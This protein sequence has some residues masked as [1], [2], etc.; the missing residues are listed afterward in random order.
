MATV[1][2]PEMPILR[3]SAD[4][5]YQRIY[6]R[7]VELASL[8]GDTPPSPEEGQIFYD[9]QYPLAEEISEQQQLDEYKFLQW[10]LPWSDG[11]F[12]DAW[13]VFLGLKRKENELDKPY[14]ERLLAKASEEEGSGAIYDYTRWVKEVP[15]A[16]E[17]Y[18]WG[19]APNTVHIAI[20]GENG[21]PASEDL[22]ATVLQHL[23][24][25][26]RHH[27]NDKLVVKPSEILEIT[28]TGTITVWEPDV[29]IE[30]NILEIEK[31]IRT[32][33]QEQTKKIVYSDLYRLFKVDGVL[34]YGQVTLNGGQ[35]NVEI[36]FASIPVI[37][38]L[39]V[40]SQ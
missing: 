21:L 27:M 22:V 29:S 26:D 15:G 34:D 32:Y 31:N 12:L 23:Q 40:T 28:I 8:R 30:A 11:E 7:A 16:G 18:I 4:E 35:A 1:K 24:R 25:E 9:F 2:K 33:V 14:R 5:I 37:K 17:A 20:T 10:F 3:E 19:E 13:G 38:S 36:P 39:V 6:N